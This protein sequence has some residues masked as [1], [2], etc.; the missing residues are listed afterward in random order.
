MAESEFPVVKDHNE[1][2]VRQVLRLIRKEIS[3]SGKRKVKRK[4]EKQKVSNE[5]VVAEASVPGDEDEPPFK[6]G[7]AHKAKKI[8]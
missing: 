1:V 5:A 2:A 8:G 4:A 6:P 7:R 3:I